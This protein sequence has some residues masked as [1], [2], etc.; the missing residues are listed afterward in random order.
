MYHFIRE[1][2]ELEKYKLKG[3]DKDQFIY[4]LRYLK[5]NFDIISFD[6]L[7]EITKKKI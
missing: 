4:Q 7:N 1:H 5:K 3:I 6:D 2:T